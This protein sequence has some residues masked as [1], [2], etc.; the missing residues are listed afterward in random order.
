MRWSFQQSPA[1]A[2][3]VRKRRQ[4]KGSL[5]PEGAYAFRRGYPRNVV[6]PC[7][8]CEDYLGKR[9]ADPPGGCYLRRAKQSQPM[10]QKLRPRHK[11]RS[12]RFVES[13]AQI[14]ASSGYRGNQWF[15]SW[16]DLFLA[17]SGCHRQ[18]HVWQSIRKFGGLV[19]QAVDLP[20][21]SLPAALCELVAFA[22]LP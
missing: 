16:S 18:T 8:R 13:P 19:R 9:V 20:D 12:G 10:P 15:L 7:P 17:G 6:T 2:I 22:V 14:P 11:N 1:R 3:A 21:S 4:T 5:P